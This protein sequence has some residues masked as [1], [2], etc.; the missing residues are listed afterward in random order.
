[1]TYKYIFPS[2]HA[3]IGN[4]ILFAAL[5]LSLLSVSACKQADVQ[6]SSQD[7]TELR[8]IQQ[9]ADEAYQ[10]DDIQTATKLYEK[11]VIDMPDVALNWYR[12][13]NLY[14][15]QNRPYTAINLYQEAISRDPALSEAWFNLSIVQLKQAAFSLNQMLENIDK[16]DP[17]YAEAA[18]LLDEIKSMMTE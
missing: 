10:A 4:G 2:Q 18:R 13:A 8:D 15:R 16:N 14:T 9:R 7:A 5:L 17:L 3:L 12:L 6:P 11:L 1:M